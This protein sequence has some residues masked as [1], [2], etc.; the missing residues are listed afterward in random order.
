V[1][2]TAAKTRGIKESR[3]VGKEMV[4]VWGSA[5]KPTC[6]KNYIVILLI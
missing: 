4:V 3:F 1:P 5:T 2:K 6:V